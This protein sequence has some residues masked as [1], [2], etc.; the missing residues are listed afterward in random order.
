LAPLL[1]LFPRSTAD[2]SRAGI[3]YLKDHARPP[4]EYVFAKLRE[5]RVLLLGETHWIRH[6]VQLVI[7]LV[8]RL[9]DAG[10]GTLALEIWPASSQ[11]T[12]DRIV[13]SEAWDPAAAMAVMRAA[14]WPYRE[15]LEILHVVWKLNRGQPANGKRLKVIALGPGGD[16]RDRLLPAGD[17]YDRFMARLIL[18]SLKQPGSR[19]L[20]YAGLH[21]AFTRY[22]QPE[23]PQA[24][25][26]ESFMD[27][28]GNILWRELGQEVFLVVLAAPWR[29]RAE[30]EESWEHCL[31]VGGA[32]DCVAAALGHP[33]AFDIPGSPFAELRISDH[34][35]YGLGYPDLRLEDFADGYVWMRRIE[36]F[37]GVALIPLSEFAPDP[38]SLAEVAANNPFSD[39]KDLKKAELEALW[40]E[41]SERLREIQKSLGWQP[42]AGWRKGCG[43]FASGP[44]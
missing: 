27:R 28:M 19:I 35:A 5:H 8:P 33:L 4:A 14:A 30:A 1:A 23:L 44:S 13:A 2:P 7:D 32:I 39:E 9:P 22:Y 29:C 37:E 26:V 25:R 10:V 20:V 40:K 41:E 11:A 38:A 16:W 15:Y 17:T 6:D 43:G 34:T 31:P 42:L 36:E 18:D 3:Q 12:L 24:T 21:H